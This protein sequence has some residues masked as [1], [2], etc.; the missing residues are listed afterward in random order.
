MFFA[1]PPSPGTLGLS[2]AYAA[3]GPIITLVLRS[4][5]S[6]KNYGK[7]NGKKILDNS[8]SNCNKDNG[9]KQ[10]DADNYDNDNWNEN[11]KKPN[12]N[13]NNNNQLSAH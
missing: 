4:S 8:E 2:G 11:N 13:N 1:H 3:S 5:N 6:K 9:G 10:D 12:D 7:K